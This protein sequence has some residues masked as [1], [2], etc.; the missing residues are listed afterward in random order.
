MT[1]LR[2]FAPVIGVLAIMFVV[3]AAEFIAMGKLKAEAVHLVGNTMPGLSHAGTVNADLAENFI[4]TL[5]VIRSDNPAERTAYLNEIARISK[6][7]DGDLQHYEEAINDD[8]NRKLYDGLVVKRRDYNEVRQQVFALV[9]EGKKDEALR[10][11]KS[12]LLPAYM[13]YTGAGESLF[14]YNIQ[15]GRGQGQQILRIYNSTR[16]L[17]AIIA[18]TSFIFGFLTPFLLI[19]F[20][21]PPD[22]LH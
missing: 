22:I 5:L 17:V 9:T 2:K 8:K 13:N 3:G 14:N 20:G 4:R 18:I 1:R 11:S 15:L 12:A 6:Q 10:L 19:R 16:F 21:G 7:I